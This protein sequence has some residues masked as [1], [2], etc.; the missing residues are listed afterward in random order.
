VPLKLT[1][2]LG[3]NSFGA[4]GEFGFVDVA[5]VFRSWLNAQATTD[6]GQILETLT[7]RLKL[8]NDTHAATVAANTPAPA[9]GE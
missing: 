7:D 9:T 6:D 4:D 5:P 3:G 1:I 2:T 8:A